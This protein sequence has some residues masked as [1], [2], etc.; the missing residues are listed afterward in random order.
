MFY[1]LKRQ[2]LSLN[3]SAL[4]F[5]VYLQRPITSKLQNTILQS[6]GQESIMKLATEYCTQGHRDSKWPQ[7]RDQSSMDRGRQG[8]HGDLRTSDYETVD[9]LAPISVFHFLT[10][11]CPRICGSAALNGSMLSN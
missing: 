3:P 6:Q 11:N 4:N 7:K 10:C 5:P 1:K 2:R 8:C 9:A